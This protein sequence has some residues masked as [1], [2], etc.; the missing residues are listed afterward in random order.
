MALQI[1]HSQ[2]FGQL[3]IFPFRVIGDLAHEF[4]HVAGKDG[5]NKDRSSKIGFPNKAEEVAVSAENLLRE[6]CCETAQ[7]KRIKY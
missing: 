6:H 3:P 5:Q 4:E 7:P 1:S 2:H